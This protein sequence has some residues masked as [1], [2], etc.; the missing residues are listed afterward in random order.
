MR[1]K[2]VLRGETC[3]TFTAR[4]GSFIAMNPLV[5]PK[6]AF[7]RET[8][9]AFVAAERFY[10]VMG[11]LVSS[12]TSR[13]SELSGTRGTRVRLFHRLRS[14]AIRQSTRVIEFSGA[15]SAGK[16][17]HSDELIFAN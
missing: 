9:L 4:I 16:T 8:L 12:E 7:C 1:S 6:L 10:S 3:R 15:Y 5:D 14:G 11:E 2:A 13:D 17:L